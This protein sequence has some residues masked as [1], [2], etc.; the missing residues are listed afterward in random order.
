MIIDIIIAFAFVGLAT[1]I[2]AAWIAGSKMHTRSSDQY[3]YKKQWDIKP[4]G[5]LMWFIIGFLVGF[6]APFTA[7]GYLVGAFGFNDF[8]WLE[9]FSSKNND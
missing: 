9:R 4:R 3:S 2:I 6:L 1:G 8:G 5:L 7:I